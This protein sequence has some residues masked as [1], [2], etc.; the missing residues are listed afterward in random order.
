MKV[1]FILLDSS[2]T[3]FEIRRILADFIIIGGG[4]AGCIVSTRLAQYGFDVLLIS[5]GSNDTL[6][7]LMYEKSLFKQLFNY[8]NYKHN[9]YTNPSI[10]LNNRTLDI[11][12]WNTLGG[13][14]INDG[15]IQRLMT[16]DWN[17]FINV[18]DDSSFHRN[19]MSKYYKLVENYTSNNRFLSSNIYGINGSIQITQP[20]DPIFYQIWK[21]IANEL[22]ETFTNNLSDNIEYGFSFEASSFTN[23]K[24]SWS[25]KNYL[26]SIKTKYS[27]LHVLT[28]TTAIKFNLNK[29]TKKIQNVLFL[30]QDGLFIGIARKEYILSAG[31]FFSPHLLMLSGIG[32]RNILQENNIT[33]KHELK[34]VGKSLTDNGVIIMK[35]KTENFSIGQSIPIALINTQFQ[36][37]MNNPN[38]FLRLKM[39]NITKDLYILIINSSPKSP[40]G[41]ISLYN[42]NPLTSP[43]ISLD[44]LNHPDDLQIFVNAILYIRKMMSTNVMKNY[45]KLI[46]ILPGLDEKDLS[47]YVKNTLTASH[48]FSGTCS[49][50]KNAEN[51]VVDNHFKVHGLYNLR[52]VDASIFPRNFTTKSGPFLTVHA[53]AEKAA[54]ILSQKYL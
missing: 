32:D 37:T 28:E 13:N 23:E 18:T 36:T 39:D 50:G 27:N 15:G 26:T 42:S 52:V 11:I 25:C 4:T 49:M 6:N 24:R 10:N 17:Y 19:T 22:N 54:H 29:Q 2:K 8:P 5:S 43:K 14:S 46:E 16:N 44:Y 3:S 45:A 35:Y 53:L 48:Y 51:S 21:N 34:Q 9:L 30:S 7:P 33:L 40:V 20:Y 1:Y 38:T 41:Y 31:T 12:V 47:K